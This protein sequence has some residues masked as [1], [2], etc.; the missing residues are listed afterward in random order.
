MEE[1]L[2]AARADLASNTWLQI[3]RDFPD[4]HF[5]IAQNKKVPIDILELLSTSPDPKARAMVVGKRK[6]TPEI[7]ARMKND[8]YDPVRQTIAGHP[9][10]PIEVVR[11]LSNDPVQ[12]VRDVAVERLRSKLKS[13]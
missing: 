6:V 7:L 13:G 11:F 8:P 2:Q 5:W 9:K 1:Y 3:M 10:T 4:M 12:V